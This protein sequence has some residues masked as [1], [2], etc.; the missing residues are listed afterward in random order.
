MN[1]NY[2]PSSNE[3]IK[4]L[5]DSEDL[6]EILMDVEDYLDTNYLYTYKN[7]IDGHVVDGPKI[8]KYWITIILKFDYEKMPDPM[9]AARLLPH[10]TKVRYRVADELRDVKVSNPG[11]Y[12]PGTHKPR[13]KKYKIWLIELQIP[14][15]FVKNLTDEVIELY[16][17]RIDIDTVEHS[18]IPGDQIQ[19]QNEDEFSDP[20]PG[21]F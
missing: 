15:R 11:D 20:L 18:T 4:R 13:E 5:T 17:E 9:G 1:T 21:G 19:N 16:S 10:G 12:Q 8:K 3:L 14:R 6:I 2:N 7:W